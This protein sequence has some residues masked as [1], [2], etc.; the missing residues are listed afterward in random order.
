MQVVKRSETWG[1]Y[2]FTVERQAPAGNWVKD[3][4]TNDRAT[5]E[6]Q[7]KYLAQRNEVARLVLEHE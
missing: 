6:Q 5:A 7:V 4:A 3:L 2:K 1:D